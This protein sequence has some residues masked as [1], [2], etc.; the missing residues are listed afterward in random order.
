M[1]AGSERNREDQR[2]ESDRMITTMADSKHNGWLITALAATNILL[3]VAGVW[4]YTE[5]RSKIAFVQTSYLLS[6]YQ[7]FKDAS[8]TYRQKSAV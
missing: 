8:V 5:S 6:N 1:P 7:G 4:L 3:I 2:N